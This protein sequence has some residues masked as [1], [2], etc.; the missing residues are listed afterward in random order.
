MRIVGIGAS[1]GGLGS[2][3]D[4]FHNT[5]CDTGMA[6]LVVQHLD[7]T[8]KAM[9]PE[10]LQRYT[11]MPVHEA[12]QN[13]PVR[14][15]SVYVIP[16]NREL[17]VLDGT[18]KLN[19]PAE[20]RGR[21]LPINVLFSSLASAQS[22]RAI[23]V[24][25]SGMGSDGTLG[26][27]AIK[28]TGGLTLVEAPD[29]AQF[30]A[31]PKSAIDAGCVDIVAAANELP[32]RILE[33]VRRVPEP[34]ESPEH[35]HR[36]L[37]S[38]RQLD[39]IFSLLRQHTRHDFSLY[40]PSTL[41]RRIERRMAIHGIA[42]LKDYTRFL[43]DNSQEVQ[44]LFQELLIGVTRFFRDPET[45]DYLIETALPELLTEQAPEHTL[46]AW[47]VGCS[48]G[49]EAYSLAI[50]FTEAQEATN[51][52]QELDLQIFASDIS[53]E[54]IT[55]AR[56][57][58]YPLSIEDTVSKDRLARFFTRHDNYYQVRP[59]IRDRILFAPH[60]VILDPPFTK[61]DMITCRNLLI[62]FD[63]ALQRRILPLFHYSLRPNGLLMLG[64]S[65]T[66]GRLNHLF[67][68]LKPRM[69]LYR[70]KR[71]ESVRHSDFLLKSFPPVS[72]MHK[73]HPVQS[74]HVPPKEA[75]DSLQSA[76]D[77]VL[78][79]VYAPAAVVLNADADIVYISGRTGKYLEPAAGKANWN[80][81]AM[82]REGLR[83]SLYT[84]LRRASEQEE[85]LELLGVMVQTDSGTQAVDVTIQT[86][87]EPEALK[88]KTMVVFRD[89]PTPMDTGRRKPASP[90]EAEHAAEIERYQKEIE[91]L[92]Q[93]AKQTREDLQA[94]N[95]ELQ[96]T[97]EEL[98]STNEELTTSKEEMQSMNEEL[99]TI[100]TELQNKLDDLALAQSDMQNVLNSIEI[101]VLFLDQDLNVRRYTERATAIISLRESDIG[102]P[103]SDLS[104][105]L[106][107][108]ELQ[109]D[110]RR[111]LDTLAVSEKQV[112]T[113]DD[114]WFTVRIM[115]YRR[116][117]NV[118]DGVVIT[119]VDI[120][121]TKQLETSLRKEPRA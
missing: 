40:K 16:P 93:Q 101:A 20:P 63:V 117:D 32:A 84:G 71:F 86:L 2:F 107:Y 4:F 23:A 64:T 89:A 22:E 44:L 70:S 114:R 53:P 3:E 78:L 72:S 34:G 47:V 83:E 94:S 43:A 99:Q 92:R 33:Y 31:M 111:T 76:A 37:K 74:S 55:V 1:A 61:L 102:R 110:A 65:E 48:T 52:G 25:L 11:E 82:A 57:G 8:Q 67:E 66:V 24:V 62:Y 39:S 79:Q 51:P 18:L 14:A 30:D 29:S 45:W 105:S 60:D 116:V 104:T 88:G 10:L 9:L 69:R 95:E 59:T 90:T 15:D 103:L 5:P 13:M 12:Q 100:N 106:D 56:R 28:A 38:L 120:T 97:N 77:H 85:P 87:H 115:P 21:R 91:S 19:Q 6:F 121:E 118:I 27:Q 49:E 108:P 35:D 58:Q 112:S 7:P 81:H 109:E 36:A 73:E 119:L 68:Q 50:A 113:D 80:I 98:Q 26:M 96:S 46:R 17:R 41:N 42:D 75:T 54:A